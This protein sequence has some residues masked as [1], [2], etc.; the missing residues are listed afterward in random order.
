[1]V[2]KEKL[3]FERGI[4]KITPELIKKL[5]NIYNDFS[6]RENFPHGYCDKVSTR[7]IDL[8]LCVT[9]GYFLV[10]KHGVWN[11]LKRYHVWVMDADKK[12][13]DLT[14][15]QFN[16]DLETPV[17]KGVL[18]IDPKEE[19]YKRYLFDKSVGFVPWKQ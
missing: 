11:T 13:I 6:Y 4:K 17:Q 1:V 2:K 19:F 5:N 16:D 9:A 3:P 12:I 7:L 14:A 8:G 15:A 18:I 10:D